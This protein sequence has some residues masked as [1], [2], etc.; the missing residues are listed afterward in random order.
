[1]ARTAHGISDLYADMPR[2]QLGRHAQDGDK[3]IVE[4]EREQHGLHRRISEL[5][6]E[7]VSLQHALRHGPARDP[8]IG[9]IAD[10]EAEN[11]ALRRQ[12]AISNSMR[13]QAKIAVELKAENSKLREV[14]NLDNPWPLADVLSRLAAA[15]DHLLDQH[16]CDCLGYEEMVEAREVGRAL[17]RKVRA[18]HADSASGD[19]KDGLGQE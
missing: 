7:I 10:L 3:R 11:E 8:L 12:N 9:R 13:E 6:G 15:V 5:K 17:A 4:L 18:L 16:N 14:L 2:E 19:E 1:M